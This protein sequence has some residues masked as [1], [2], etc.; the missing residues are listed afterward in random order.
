[1]LLGD[2]DDPVADAADITALLGAARRL[3][4]AQQGNDPELDELARRLVD[5]TALS[6]DLGADFGSYAAAIDTDSARLE[7]IEMRRAELA[8]LVRKYGDGPDA[9]LSAVHA[10]AD[11]ARRRLADLDVSDEAIAALTARRD[12]TAGR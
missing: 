12:E 4:D 10:W 11:V 1:A 7:Q 2:P 6:A 3:L 5:L 8:A 9:G